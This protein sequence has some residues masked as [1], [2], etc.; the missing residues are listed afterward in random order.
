MNVIPETLKAAL[1][2]VSVSVLLGEALALVKTSPFPLTG[3]VPPQFAA[4]T[5]SVL[6]EEPVQVVACTAGLEAKIAPAAA[7][8]AMAMPRR[9]LL[10]QVLVET[11]V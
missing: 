10:P 2:N 7:T 9:A 11:S 3:A 5:Q 4:V 1:V 8:A 6:P